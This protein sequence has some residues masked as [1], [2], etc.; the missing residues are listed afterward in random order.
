MRSSIYS[1]RGGE[2]QLFEK[3][4]NLIDADVEELD[5]FYRSYKEIMENVKLGIYWNKR[6]LE[7]FGS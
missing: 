5:R 2:K 1:W 4:E 7:L 6:G 3:L